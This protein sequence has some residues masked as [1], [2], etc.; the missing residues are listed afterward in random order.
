MLVKLWL[1]LTSQFLYT[2]TYNR[3][4]MQSNETRWEATGKIPW[5]QVKLILVWLNIVYHHQYY[6]LIICRSHKKT[7][8]LDFLRPSKDNWYWA[9]N[10]LSCYF[11]FLERN[12]SHKV[13]TFNAHRHQ[14]IN[15]VTNL[16]ILFLQTSNLLLIDLKCTHCG[17]GCPLKLG[18]E[19][20]KTWWAT[21][22]ESTDLLRQHCLL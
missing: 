5:F 12:W 21:N 15:D 6:F 20:L 13:L 19:P 4:T 14:I 2:T 9:K 22:K 8:T 16:K 7:Q 1:G 17:C 3:D 18:W 11:I 10:Y